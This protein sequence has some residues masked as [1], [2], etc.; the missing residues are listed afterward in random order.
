ML[1]LVL[2]VLFPITP[3]SGLFNKWLLVF[4]VIFFLSAFCVLGLQNK[5]INPQTHVASNEI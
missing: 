2:Q 5:K 3:I 1:L 4:N